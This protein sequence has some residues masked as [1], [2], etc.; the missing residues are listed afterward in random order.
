MRR[1]VIPLGL[2]PLLAACGQGGDAAA[3]SEGLIATDPVIARALHDPLMSDPDLASRNEAASAIGFADSAALP[4]FAGSSEAAA[5]AREAMRIELLESG[6][7][8]DLPAA[9]KASG[10]AVLGPM[11]GAQELLAAVG[12][13]G[14]CA[15][16]LKED[17]ALAA[18][19]PPAAAIPPRAMVVQAGASAAKGCGLTIIRY[20][21]PA[22]SEDVLQ[23]HH[24]S[25]ARAG[26]EPVRH[27]APGD[28]IVGQGKGT[29]RLVVSLRKAANGL[30]GVTLVYRK[31]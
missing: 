28:S 29:E 14:T 15:A 22:A 30:T 3:G 2:L 25:A 6:P 18:K 4:V 5:A 11:S 12:A 27:A 20:L 16:G 19:L 13:P 26:L 10:P 21:T 1:A 31:N 23:Y 8:P 17:F 9:S 24:V 7:L